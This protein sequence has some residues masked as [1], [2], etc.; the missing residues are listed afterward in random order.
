[1]TQADSIV[2]SEDPSTK[3][4][5]T[6]KLELDLFWQETSDQARRRYLLHFGIYAVLLVTTV[7]P[8]V[9]VF[10][11]IEPYVLGMPFL[12]FWFTL[13]LVFITINSYLLYRFDEGK[14]IGGE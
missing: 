14:V 13:V 5:E 6:S 4:G 7:W 12:I 1:M 8:V 3:S 11:Q 9:L 2:S 10:N